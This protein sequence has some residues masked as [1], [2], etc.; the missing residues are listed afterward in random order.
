MRGKAINGHLALSNN[1]E[2]ALPPRIQ[3]GKTTEATTGRQAL[4]LGALL[5]GASTFFSFNM[6]IRNVSRHRRTENS[7]HEQPQ[8]NL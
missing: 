4:P 6:K 2:R 7:Q 3:G 8:D 1:L 5:P